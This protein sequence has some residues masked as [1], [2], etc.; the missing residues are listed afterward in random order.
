MNYSHPKLLLLLVV[1]LALG[2]AALVGGAGTDGWTWD[3]SP[4]APSTGS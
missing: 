4:S 3:D 1:V 2:F